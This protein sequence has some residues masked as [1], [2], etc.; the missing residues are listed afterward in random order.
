L[1]C[2]EKEGRKEGR[3]ERKR[4]N[5]VDFLKETISH[6]SLSQYIFYTS[7]ITTT[8]PLH[9]THIGS[10]EMIKNFARK[11]RVYISKANE[12][13]DGDYLV[14]HTIV[15]YLNAP[16]GE[17]LDFFSQGMHANDIVKKIEENAKACP[18]VEA[19]WMNVWKKGRD[20]EEIGNAGQFVITE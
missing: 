3:K 12:E 6:F 5:Q 17:F 1:V 15:L 8:N 18:I 13:E 20:E 4:L 7:I 2:W 10:P 14:D 16:D 9:N 11:Y 19:K